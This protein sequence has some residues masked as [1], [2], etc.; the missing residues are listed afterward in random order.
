MIQVFKPS[1]GEEEFQAVKEVMQS[2][3]IGLGPK[4]QEFEEKFANYVGSKY[5][6]GLNSGTAALHL[7]LMGY[8]LEPGDEVI[9]PALTFISTVHAIRY[10]GATPVFAD[11]YEDTLCIDVNDVARKITS[12]TRAVLPVHYGGHPCDMD[13]LRVLTDPRGI[14]VVED[15]AHAAGARYKT[16]RVGSLSQATCFSFHAVKNLTMGEGGAIA[17]DDARLN[18]FARKLRWVGINKDTWSRSS[19]LRTYGWYYE[20]EELGFKYHLSDIPASI[21]IVQLTK[22]DRANGRRRELVEQYNAALTGVPWLSTPVQRDYV[23]SACHNYVIKTDYRDRLNLYLKEKGIATGV[24]YMPAHLHPIY[25][26]IVANVPVTDRVWTRLLTL[27][28]YPDLTEED[29]DLIITSIKGFV[30]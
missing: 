26:G 5:V 8:H 28:L 4:T 7:A 11:V 20:V 17:T 6:I 27:P 9:V 22:L 16:R 25:H 23:L 29:M 10:V 24:H 18:D 21:G 2:G 1:L 12:R 14:L 30:P 19:D 3:W 15:A 13:E